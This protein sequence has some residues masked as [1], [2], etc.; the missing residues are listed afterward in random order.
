MSKSLEMSLTSAITKKNLAMKKKKKNEAF[1][2]AALAYQETRMGKMEE[3]SK[4]LKQEAV[5][6]SRVI[7]T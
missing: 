2:R 4:R 5:E 6:I 1:A 7:I 3:E